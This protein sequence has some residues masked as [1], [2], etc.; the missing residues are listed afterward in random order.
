MWAE[1]QT[2]FWKKPESDFS[3]LEK[4]KYRVWRLRHRMM[5][6]VQQVLAFYTSEVIEPNWMEFEEKLSK[7]K[8]V[9]QLMNDHTDL[10]NNCRTYCLLSHS[11]FVEVSEEQKSL[12]QE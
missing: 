12:K 9:D 5:F 3:A 7:V 8:T 6:F 1:H 4:W 10:L 2:P 11:D